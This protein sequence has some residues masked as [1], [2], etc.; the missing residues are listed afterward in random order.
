M[1]IWKTV[2]I[3]IVILMPIICCAT[4]TTRATVVPK[5]DMP[6]SETTILND[7]GIIEKTRSGDFL[8]FLR[9]QTVIWFSWKYKYTQREGESVKANIRITKKTIEVNKGDKPAVWVLLTLTVIDLR[10]G[11]PKYNIGIYLGGKNE[12]TG[13][14]KGKWMNATVYEGILPLPLIY[15]ITE[16][17]VGRLE[18]PEES[19]TYRYTYTVGIV[20]PEGSESWVNAT[21]PVTVKE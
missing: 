18:V 8:D 4:P 19:G 15:S 3:T 5:V 7:I 13:V 1:R 20:G 2:A 14:E 6:N 11:R 16:M 17:K 9:P 10:F 21:L 12:T